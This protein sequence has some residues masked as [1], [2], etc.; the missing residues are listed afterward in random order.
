MAI[1]CQ[2]RGRFDQSEDAPF[3]PDSATERVQLLVDVSSD[4]PM[5]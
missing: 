3:W 1:S 4:P 5:E 2:L